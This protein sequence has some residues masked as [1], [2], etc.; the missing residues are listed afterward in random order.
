MAIGA[1]AEVLDE[2]DAAA[3]EYVAPMVPVVMK[4]LA[5]SDPNVRAS[6]STQPL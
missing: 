1:V 4:G 2:I 5:D 3:A 6:V